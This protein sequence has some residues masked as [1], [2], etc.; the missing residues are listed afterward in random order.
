MPA[1]PLVAFLRNIKKQ[2]EAA[3]PWARVAAFFLLEPRLERSTCTGTGEPG[4]L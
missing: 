4:I 2:Q 3:S 1:R